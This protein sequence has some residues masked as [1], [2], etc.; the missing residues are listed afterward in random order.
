MQLLSFKDYHALSLHAATLIARAIRENPRLTLCMASGHTP[1]LTCELLA[2]QL[3]EDKTDYS[4]L[5][6]LGLD[7][8]VGLSP[9]NPGSC[10]YF[11]KTKLFDPLQLSPSQYHLFN[12]QSPDLAAECK[13]MDERIAA[14]GGIDMVLVGIG[15]NGHIGF[16]EPGTA[17]DASCHV[18]TLDETTKTVGQKYFN[19]S[20]ELSQGITIGLGHLQKAKTV[21]LLAN[22]AKKAAVIRQTVESPVTENFPASIMQTHTNGFVLID[23][24]AG[25]LLKQ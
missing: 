19:E 2:E 20:M 15:M 16:N 7:E 23:E 10:H 11:F 3:K 25:S 24:E 1:S 18:A 9:E 17:I 22:G 13:K 5:L 12:A 8:W 6:F 14:A 4:S 21:L